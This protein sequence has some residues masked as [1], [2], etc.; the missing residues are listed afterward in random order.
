MYM[1]NHPDTLVGYAKYYGK[2][3]EP[4]KSAEMTAIDTKSMTLNCTM[5]SGGQMQVR[6]DIDPPLKDYNDVKPRL[7][8]MKALSQEGLGMIKA[9]H[10]TTFQFPEFSA[11][12]GFIT[13]YVAAVLYLKFAPAEGNSVWWVPAQLAHSYPYVP[14]VVNFLFYGTTV[15]HILES[16]Y[17]FSLCRKHYTPFTATMAYVGSTMVYGVSIWSDLR[18]RIQTAR[19]DSV[20]KVE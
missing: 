20:M 16:L 3:T 19:I 5:K 7:L 14:G 10:I 6:V 2:V 11:P 4:I 17:T 1:S 18:K 9:P 8:E 12:I 13:V 15:T